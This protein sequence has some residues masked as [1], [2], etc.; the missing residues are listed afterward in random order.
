[1]ASTSLKIVILMAENGVRLS[2]HTYSRP[3][4]LIRMADRTV[5]DQ[6]LNI[7]STHPNPIYSEFIF[8][9]GYLGGKIEDY[10]CHAHL[11]LKMRCVEQPE[12][13]GH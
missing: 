8:I 7:L 4:Q 11:N 2:P 12:M 5:I 1:M 3:L 6:I 13:L 9:V 10:M